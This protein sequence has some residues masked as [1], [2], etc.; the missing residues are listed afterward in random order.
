MNERERVYASM[1]LEEFV[2]GNCLMAKSIESRKIPRRTS[3][4]KDFKC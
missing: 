3:A 1:A 4:R 2:T